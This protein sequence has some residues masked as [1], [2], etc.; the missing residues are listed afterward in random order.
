MWFHP[1]TPPFR[2]IGKSTDFNKFPEKLQNND[3]TWRML[4]YT[5]HLFST[6]KNLCFSKCLIEHNDKKI[7]SVQELSDWLSKGVNCPAPHH[8]ASVRSCL[9][10]AANKQSEWTRLPSHTAVY[11]PRKIFNYTGLKEL[12][13][14]L[15]HIVFFGPLFLL[16]VLKSLRDLVMIF[17]ALK[18]EE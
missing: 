1:S 3:K 13:Q 5:G 17:N 7:I 10:R 8:E 9:R 16:I 18:L 2:A 12:L 14:F 15:L 6:Y 11:S 4:N